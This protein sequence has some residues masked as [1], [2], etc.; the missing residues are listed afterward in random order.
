[1]AER[2]LFRKAQ[3]LNADELQVKIAV[4]LSSAFSIRAGFHSG[5]WF[6][7]FTFPLKS[8]FCLLYRIPV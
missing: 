2:D 3:D 6:P 8:A 4:M 5:W 1:M 7:R